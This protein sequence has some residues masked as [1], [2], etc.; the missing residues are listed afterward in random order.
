MPRLKNNG[1][2]DQLTQLYRRYAGWLKRVVRKRF[3]AED[4]DDIV[5]ET[6]LRISRLAD[7]NVVIHP[8]ALLLKVARNTAIDRARRAGRGALALRLDCIE[9]REL[10]LHSHQ[11]EDLLLKQIILTMPLAYR[12]VFVLS[13]FSGLTYQEIAVRL[14]LSVKTVEWRMSKA[15]GHCGRKLQGE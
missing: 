14:G 13:R 11:A 15:L 2:N 12:D 7:E 5:Q 9:E 1:P 4:A 8:K 10:S 3:A 6:Y